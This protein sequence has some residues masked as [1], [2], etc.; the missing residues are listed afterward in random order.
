MG[1]SASRQGLNPPVKIAM[2]T[3]FFFPELGG[4]RD[5]IAALGRSL[6][7]RGHEICIYALRYGNRDYLRIDMPAHG[8]LGDNVR[9]HHCLSVPFP[10]STRQSRIAL[11]SLAGLG[12]RPDLIHVHSFFAVGLEG[13]LRGMPVTGTNHTMTPGSARIFR[14]PW[15]MHP[16]M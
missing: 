13:V 14:S 11:P 7:L 8:P 3:D 2:F 15:T 6:G 16:H 9:M 12:R 10:S 4:I 1:P 5:S